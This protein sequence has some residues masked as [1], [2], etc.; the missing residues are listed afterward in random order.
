MVKTKAAIISAVTVAVLLAYGTAGAAIVVFD[1]VTVRN[2]PVQLVVLTKG[3]LFPE[4]GQ[5]VTVTVGQ[6]GLNKMLT[7]GDGYGYLMYSPTEAGL[8]KI[9]A[10]YKNGRG[11]GTLLVMDPK[12]RAILV[13]VDTATRESLLAAGLRQGTRK[14]IETIGKKYRIIY[15]HGMT[16]L[17]LARH[18]INT[19]DLPPSVVLSWRNGD[20]L[21]L[22][23]RDGIQVHAVIGSA[24]QMAAA[25]KFIPNRF[26]FEKANAGRQVESW[27]E[28]VKALGINESPGSE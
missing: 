3:K 10:G 12:E 4:G 22:L 21:K 7:G 11:S 6:T 2:Q 13:D 23:K 15:L 14:A 9:S 25:E 27:E 18:W 1:R 5:L 20:R 8:I 24:D 26:S 16:G 28:V 19:G 17:A